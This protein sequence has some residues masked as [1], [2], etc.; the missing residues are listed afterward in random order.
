ME[1]FV[2]VYGCGC[3]YLSVCTYVQVYSVKIVCRFAYLLGFV[4][5]G[6]VCICVFVYLSVGCV[7]ACVYICMYMALCMKAFLCVLYIQYTCQILC[8]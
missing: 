6:H 7:Y 8:V 2:L 3:V 1:L 5:H 4:F